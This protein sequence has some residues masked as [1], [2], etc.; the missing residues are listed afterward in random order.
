MSDVIIIAGG[1]GT[2]LHSVLKDVPKGMAVIAGNPFLAYLLG[3]LK[4]LGYQ[5][6][7]LS[8]GYL[9]EQ[10]VNYFSNSWEGLSIKYSIE[11]EPLGTGGAVKKALQFCKSDNVLVMNG[12]TLFAIDTLKLN[13]VL[14]QPGTQIVLALREVD[15]ADRY[16]KVIL[17]E[18]GRVLEFREKSPG[19]SAGLINGG[20]YLMK[21]D[22]MSKEGLPEKFSIEQ[23]F[24]PTICKA[25]N[26]KGV[27]YH[28]YF[29][30]IGIPEDLARAQSDFPILAKKY[31][32]TR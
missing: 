14:D 11:D 16:G 23:E 1:K 12:D 22:A 3:Y 18:N 15:N 30:D 28:D 32:I 17:D 25:G 19:N 8:V 9:H 13:S 6:I 31:G 7:V 2:R 26:M 20:V 24:F 27:V 21:K 29:L 4:Y 10:I 5:N